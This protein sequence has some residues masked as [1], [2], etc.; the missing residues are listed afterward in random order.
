M[1]ITSLGYSWIDDLQHTQ[2][3]QNFPFNF[4]LFWEYVYECLTISMIMMIFEDSKFPICLQL[5]C[6]L[7]CDRP[8]YL[9]QPPKWRTV[10]CCSMWGKKG[11]GLLERNTLETL[12]L[13]RIWLTNVSFGFSSISTILSHPQKQYLRR[14]L[15]G[16]SGPWGCAPIFA[17]SGDWS[18][19]L[20]KYMLHSP[21]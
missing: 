15:A 17:S 5:A 3:T 9:K 13:W 6:L 12:K 16:K 21:C 20:S 2:F 7:Y 14:I 11:L 4:P 1:A 10:C 18:I 8:L 19:T